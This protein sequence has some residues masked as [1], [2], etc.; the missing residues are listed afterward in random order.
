MEVEVE[1]KQHISRES[2]QTSPDLINE[3]LKSIPQ[4]EKQYLIIKPIGEKEYFEGKNYKIC[5]TEN[6]WQVELEKG[7]KY[8][9]LKAHKDS[10]KHVFFLLDKDLKFVMTDKQSEKI[11]KKL[12]LEVIKKFIKQVNESMHKED[13]SIKVIYRRSLILTIMGWIIFLILIMSSIGMFSCG[14]YISYL[15]GNQNNYQSNFGKTFEAPFYVIT[16]ASLAMAVIIFISCVKNSILKEYHSQRLKIL[17]YINKIKKIETEVNEELKCKGVF[18]TVSPN[19]EY[20]H[21]SLEYEEL[22]ITYL[23]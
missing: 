2:Y 7:R 15:K 21:F 10:E 1:I 17:L 23:F 11:S 8:S 5:K 14:I 9:Y 16:C 13:N 12:N 3:T 20:I 22:R 4:L 6:I 19:L 18:V